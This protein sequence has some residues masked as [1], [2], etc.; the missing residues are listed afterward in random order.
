M[1]AQPRV[2]GVRRV[3]TYASLLPA[4][5]QAVAKTARQFGVSKGWVRATALAQYFGVDEQQDYRA[6]VNVAPMRRRRRA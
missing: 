4:I 3:P 2:K 5:E 6:G 1:N